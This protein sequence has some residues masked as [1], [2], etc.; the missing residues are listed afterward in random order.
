MIN[1]NTSF[2]KLKSVIVGRE[3]E[4][5]KRIA[6]FSFK[7]FYQE[8]LEHSVYE[9]IEFEDEEYYVSHEA[10]IK[11]NEQLDHLAI[12]LEGLDIKVHRP[13]KL[14]KVIPV[15]T[16]DFKSELSS[17]S[18]V[19]DL[20]L[21]YKD[22]IIETP[23]YVQN[24]YFE[25]TSMY[26][27][28]NR[29]FD[30]GR[31]GQWIRPPFNSIVEEKIDL[32][33]WKEKRDYENFD[34]ERYTMAIDGAQYLRI[35]KDVIVNINSY[36]H[37]LGHEWLKSFFPES[38]FHMINVADN[39]I[40]GVI[41]CLAPGYFLVNPKFKH[42]VDMMPDKFKNWNYLIPRDD[43]NYEK[44]EG[45]TNLDIHLAS[46][47]GMD[48]NILSVDEKNVLIN[49]RANSVAEILDQ[50]HFNI[51]QIELDNCEVFGGGIHC[52][53]LDLLRDDEYIDYTR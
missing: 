12:V 15:M 37:C 3:L 30:G 25:N 36:N 32:S 33:N 51:T 28:F 5:P 13:D 4:L 31:G 38:N 18:N 7:H 47:R 9:K 48:I 24:R 1:S 2:G 44:E 50:Y 17:A 52:S 21:V 20:T 6:D 11:R 42:I 34:R 19:R 29:A 53:T 45:M 41:V 14:T 46:S 27:I 49:K 8:N 16:P 22:K 23:T 10:L 40:D 35:G 39:H 43:F 26:S